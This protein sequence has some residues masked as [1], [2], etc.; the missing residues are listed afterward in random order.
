MRY[1]RLILFLGLLPAIF[2]VT[3]FAKKTYQIVLIGKGNI[4]YYSHQNKIVK[5]TGFRKDSGFAEIYKKLYLTK[6]VSRSS[7]FNDYSVNRF[8]AEY[9]S[10]RFGRDQLSKNNNFNYRAKP[11]YENGILQNE[12]YS[13][14]NS[15]P[16]GWKPKGRDAGLVME[17]VSAN[18]P[19]DGSLDVYKD[20]I[21]MVMLHFRDKPTD[22]F[23]KAAKFSLGVS[24]NI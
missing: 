20:L 13:K 14:N 23:Y 15:E 4:K 3:Y 11:D 2:L 7:F 1:Q 12:R 8:Y 16:G 17:V 10:G 18:D 5:S 24:F 21:R 22:D 9:S 6:Q 19:E